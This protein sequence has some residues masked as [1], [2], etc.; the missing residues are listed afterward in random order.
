[1][2]NPCVLFIQ[3]G[4]EGAHAEDKPLAESLKRALGASYDVRFPQMPDE[5]NPDAQSWGRKI[6][7]DLSRIPGRVI[8]VAHSIGG[9]ILLKY[10]AEVQVKNPIAGLFL[11]AAPSWDGDRW[12]FNDLKLPTDIAERL[13]QVPKVFF[14]HCRDDNIVPFAHLALHGTRLPDAVMRA[15]DHGGHQFDEDLN[16]VASDIRSSDAAA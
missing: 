8:L 2:T 1:M 7:Q 5:A 14:Y 11:L 15:I 10:L 13:A 12:N 4:G 9:S 16:F 6:S 3:G